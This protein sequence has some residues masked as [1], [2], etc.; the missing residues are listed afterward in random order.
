MRPDL[1]MHIGG[2]K[3]QDG[4]EYR[5]LTRNDA[6]IIWAEPNL[7]NAEIIRKKFP[8]QQVLN[9][10]FWSKKNQFINFYETLDSQ[11]SS[12]KKP[13]GDL[14]RS[15]VN[16]TMLQSTTVDDKIPKSSKKALMVLDVQGGEMEVLQGARKSFQKIKWVILEITSTGIEYEDIAVE[17]NLDLLLAIHGFRKSIYR[18]SHNN[19]YKDQLYVRASKNQIIFMRLLDSSLIFLREFLHFVRRGH[20]LTNTWHCSRCSLSS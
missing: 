15:V 9:M 20:L 3:G 18:Q 12:A 19:E 8:D 17:N 6:R 10:L 4:F 13:V 11:K 1:V 7:A 2:H 5:V 14:A 16:E